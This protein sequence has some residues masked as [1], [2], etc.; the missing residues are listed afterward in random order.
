MRDGH[1]FCVRIN[2]ERETNAQQQG[3]FEQKILRHY[4]A[5][6]LF[7]VRGGLKLD[8]FG[9]RAKSGLYPMASAGQRARAMLN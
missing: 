3:G 2:R 6:L 4:F 9:P 7:G 5:A 1:A 8:R